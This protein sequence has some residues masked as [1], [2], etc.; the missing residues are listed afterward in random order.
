MI[1]SYKSI[2]SN[3]IKTDPADR[4]II[5]NRIKPFSKDV[6]LPLLLSAG[7][8]RRCKRRGPF[9]L[10]EIRK[11]QAKTAAAGSCPARYFLEEGVE[12]EERA[13][14]GAYL[15]KKDPSG[16]GTPDSGR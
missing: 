14:Y 4:R 10:P 13:H 16:C 9:M 12:E 15:R 3:T 11:Y 8:E 6:K 5:A 1:M 7:R 2:S